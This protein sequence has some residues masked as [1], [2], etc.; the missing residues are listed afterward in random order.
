[1]NMK[2]G[3]VFTLCALALAA[4]GSVAHA[5]LGAT[6]IAL[7][8][9]LRYTDP[10][11][12]TEGGTWYLVAR[13]GSTDGIAGV[14]A[15]IQN[16]NG[17]GT[18][19]LGNNGVVGNGYTVAVTSNT[20]GSIE[21]GA[22]GSNSA[23]ATSA[24]GFVNVVYG[25]NTAVVENGS[26]KLDVGGGTGTPGN[27]ALDPL[28]NATWNNSALLASG[29]FGG[30]RPVF[31]TAGTTATGGNVLP[32]GATA[33]PPQNTALTATNMSGANLVVRG[34]SLASLGLNANPAAGLKRGDL[35]RDFDV[36]ITDLG[37]MA[38]NLNQP[39]PVGGW[40]WGAG[41]TD[42]DGDVDITDL[43]NLATNLNQ[44]PGI[45]PVTSVPEP[46][47]ASMG[48]IAVAALA[49]RRRR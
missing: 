38:T 37:N 42:D 33:I 9:N 18:V 47:A 12:P 43:G 3:L 46:A 45:P 31:G 14:S 16:I 27:I 23:Y 30:T 26:I 5:Q 22:A 44:A 8:L 15:W 21:Q 20:I 17:A 28:K 6:D 11:D 32:V 13:T 48:L 41:D 35:D 4:S 24:S 2:R 49:R 25:Q 34:D 10:A 1:M 39:A 36:D 40:G 29:T 7:S 19:F